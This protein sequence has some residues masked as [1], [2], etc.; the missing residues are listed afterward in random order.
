MILQQ[1]E[2]H[3]SGQ[4]SFEEVGAGYTFFSSGVPIG[5][6]QQAGVGFAIK[7]SIVRKLE[8]L[9]K[10]IN[11][12]LMLLRLNL[13]YGQSATLISAYAPTLPASD[14]FKEEIYE[15][16]TNVIDSVP[17]R[18]KLFLLGDFN[19]HVGQNYTSW[20][21]VIGP[22]GVERKNANGTLL[23]STCSQYNLVITNTIFQQSNKYK[24]T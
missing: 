17:R 22:H 15:E 16:L 8:F 7:S 10:G 1:S 11:S 23:L 9:P 20:C 2:T 18:D 12:R 21:K 13:P 19:A 6:P 24:T 14:A 5:E 3:L 4:Q